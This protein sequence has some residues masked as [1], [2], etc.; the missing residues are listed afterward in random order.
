MSE[1]R[2]IQNN[3]T[4]FGLNNEC[5][6]DDDVPAL[7]LKTRGYQAWSES[8][9]KQFLKDLIAVNCSQARTRGIIPIDKIENEKL[10]H[11]SDIGKRLSV[12]ALN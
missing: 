2:G 12:D 5:Q 10:A 4:S 7:F 6:N 11:V 1:T 3:D 9:C 8:N